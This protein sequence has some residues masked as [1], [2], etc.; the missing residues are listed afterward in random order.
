MSGQ[1]EGHE[2]FGASG[3]TRPDPRGGGGGVGGQTCAPVPG[4]GRC[5][6]GP[7]AA[8]RS[9]V[10]HAAQSSAVKGCLP[11]ATRRR[12]CR[13]APLPGQGLSLV[14][15]RKSA[16]LRCAWEAP[17]TPPP[18]KC[19]IGDPPRPPGAGE[20]EVRGDTPSAP[21]WKWAKG[22]WRATLQGRGGGGGRLLWRGGWASTVPR[23]VRSCCRLP[24]TRRQLIRRR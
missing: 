7:V 24:A 20:G 2:R 10:A 22:F 8:F 11:M 13:S 16:G 14:H 17:R 18:P 15:K 3:P 6:D 23:R 9:A 19:I 1:C 12:G 5:G 4:H 21:K